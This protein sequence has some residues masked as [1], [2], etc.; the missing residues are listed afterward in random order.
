MRDLEEYVG[1]VCLATVA[2]GL[3]L[4]GVELR[5]IAT[6][7]SLLGVLGFL[8]LSLK[9]DGSMALMCF[10][11]FFIHFFVLIASYPE[12]GYWDI[13]WRVRRVKIQVRKMI[14]G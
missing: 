2:F 11:T 6:I 12:Q 9:T 4:K 13:A 8:V 1:V 5:R 3:F 14:Q 7:F 10:I